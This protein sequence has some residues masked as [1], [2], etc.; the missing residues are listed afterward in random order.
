MY[1]CL[2]MY[3]HVW[4]ITGF[5]SDGYASK[6]FKLVPARHPA[7]SKYLKLGPGRRPAASKYFK[8]G[9]WMV[10]NEEQDSPQHRLEAFRGSKKLRHG[11]D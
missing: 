11:R 3:L 10:E 1:R 2:C 8:P 5:T 4:D 6:Y 7:A 9:G